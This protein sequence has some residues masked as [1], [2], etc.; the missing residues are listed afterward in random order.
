MSKLPEP[1]TQR[2]QIKHVEKYILVKGI[3]KENVKSQLLI[4]DQETGR[5]STFIRA[6]SLPSLLRLLSQQMK[7]PDE[8]ETNSSPDVSHDG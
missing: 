2:R 6:K 4:L 8:Q 1:P 5:V 3:S 7:K